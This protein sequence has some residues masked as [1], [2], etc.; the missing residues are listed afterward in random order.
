MATSPQTS[1]YLSII[2]L[3]YHTDEMT[4][5][6]VKKIEKDNDVEVIL[7][8]NS[9]S[10]DLEKKAKDLIHTVYL[11]PGNNLGFAGGVNLGINKSGGEWIFLLNSDVNTDI[12]TIKK[13]IKHCVKQNMKI[14]APRL[15]REDG[16]FETNVGFFSGFFKHPINWLFLRPLFI[17]PDKDT[18]VHV[19]TGG[20]LLL[21]RSV[22][23]RVGLLDDKN[24]FMYFEDMDYS[25]RLH[26][27]GV[28]ILYVPMCNITH[29]GGGSADKNPNQKKLSYFTSLNNYLLKHRGP[30]FVWLNNLFHVL[31]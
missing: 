21:H 29:V 14:A 3:N 9:S 24:F 4:Y 12:N 23:E 26:S 2:I 5:R 18:K 11:N 17:L 28:D 6:L 19:A 27:A 7:V 1:P 30:F 10:K 15:V 8:D 31:K 13:L 25:W 16:K 22:I 20:V